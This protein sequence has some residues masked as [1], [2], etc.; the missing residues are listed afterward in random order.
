MNRTLNSDG[1]SIFV[2]IASYIS[3]SM[4]SLFQDDG[5]KMIR[6]RTSGLRNLGNTCFMNAVLQSL[7]FVSQTGL[8]KT[9]SF[10]ILGLMSIR[11]VRRPAITTSPSPNFR[12]LLNHFP[13]IFI[14][15]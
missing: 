4:P 13:Q 12:W 2:I 8:I 14:N 9:A 15:F 10:T 11:H 7:R 6:P 1:I 5:A 3:L